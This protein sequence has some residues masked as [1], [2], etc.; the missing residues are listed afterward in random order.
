MK[1]CHFFWMLWLQKLAQ[2]AA[3]NVSVLPDLF[4]EDEAGCCTEMSM[5]GVIAEKEQQRW[6]EKENGTVFVIPPSPRT[7]DGHCR[8]EYL[9]GG[10]P[11]CSS[12]GWM[13]ELQDGD[14]TTLGSS[15]EDTLS[16]DLERVSLGS[17]GKWTWDIHSIILDLST[18]NFTD[19]VAIKM[20]KNVS[21]SANQTQKRTK[22]VLTSLVILKLWGKTSNCPSDALYTPGM[23]PPHGVYTG[24][25]WGGFFYC[26]LAHVID[27][28]ENTLFF[29]LSKLILLL[30]HYKILDSD[31]LT[32]VH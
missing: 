18:A 3:R 2:T 22:N 30:Y 8:W 6:S 14:T 5:D 24:Q 23:R 25:A 12:L 13:S 29:L 10:D 9:K 27:W 16:R 11:D 19:T 26:F 7:L 21:K 15:S 32:G 4:V 1:S 20:L 17:L 31:W 28:P